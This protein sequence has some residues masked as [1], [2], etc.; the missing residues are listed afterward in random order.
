MFPETRGKTLEEI[1]VL[2]DNGVPAWK[3]DKVDS[4]LDNRIHELEEKEH[5][6]ATEIEKVKQ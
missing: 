1:D 2:F 3:S 6:I 5:G 4:K